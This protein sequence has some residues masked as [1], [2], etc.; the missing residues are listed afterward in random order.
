MLELNSPKARNVKFKDD[1]GSQTSIIPRSS[2]NPGK[3]LS[4]YEFV[5]PP[6]VSLEELKDTHPELKIE[7]L[8]YQRREKKT[9]TVNDAQWSNQWHLRTSQTPSMNVYNAWDKGF[10]GSGVTIAI[11]DDGIDID[12]SDLLDNYVSLKF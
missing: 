7:K 10:N 2:W 9:V 5:L 11:V 12:H 3:V 8:S 6:S 4:R 1:S